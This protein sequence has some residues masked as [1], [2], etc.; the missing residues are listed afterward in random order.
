MISKNLFCSVMERL[1]LQILHDKEVGSLFYIS[2]GG[3]GLSS[4]SYDNRLVISALLDLLHEYF[5][6]DEDGF[7]E[8]EHYIF[9]LEFGKSTN[10]N[11]TETFEKLYKRLLNKL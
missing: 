1:M 11:E 3:I 9:D 8:L 2:A 6:K 7:S 10:D 5:P 4:C